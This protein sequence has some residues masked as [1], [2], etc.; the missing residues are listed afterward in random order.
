MSSHHKNNS[1]PSPKENIYQYQVGGINDPRHYFVRAITPKAKVLDV[2][3]ACGD[4]GFALHEKDE[5]ILIYGME[6]D[7]NSIAVAEQTNTYKHIWQAD[8]NSFEAGTYAEHSQSF[9]FIIF[10]DVLEHLL[11]PAAVLEKFKALL[12]PTGAF[13]LSIPNI[14]HASIKANLL[15]NHFDYTQVGLL[16]KTHL[17]FFTFRSIAKLLSELGLEIK[18]CN[19][20]AAN[21][22]AYQ[23]TNPYLQLPITVKYFI[24]KDYHS[25]VM[26]YVMQV[27]ISG[28]TAEQ[29]TNQNTAMLSIN[30]PNVPPQIKQMQRKAFRHMVRDIFK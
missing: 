14:A 22:I 27:V 6:Y 4:L 21:E 3:C 24:F 15:I 20:T 19:F 2:G 13:L 30:K 10:G 1:A 16:D 7:E 17:R 25:F 11:N 9:D 5:S 29:L 8:L 12:K 23:P 28:K 26:Q 18:L